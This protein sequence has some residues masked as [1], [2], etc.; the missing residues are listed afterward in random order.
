MSGWTKCSDHCLFRVSAVG[1]PSRSSL[2]P[3]DRARDPDTT[4]TP[5]CSGRRHLLNDSAFQ[6]TRPRPESRVETRA[7]DGV[8]DMLLTALLIHDVHAIEVRAVRVSV[9]I[10]VNAIGART[11]PPLAGRSAHPDDEAANDRLSAASPYQRRREPRP[12][13]RLSPACPA[14]PL[15][16]LVGIPH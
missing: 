5:A 11:S 7:A 12:C 2:P 1:R 14:R 6:M 4:S 13:R 15:S 3:E 16:R 10:V 9:S 8:T